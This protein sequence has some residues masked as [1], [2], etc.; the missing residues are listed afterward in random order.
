MIPSKL[1]LII[2]KASNI[3][4]QL[5]GFGYYS[6][7]DWSSVTIQWPKVTSNTDNLLPRCFFYAQN[8]TIPL[9]LQIDCW[10][11]LALCLIAF[12]EFVKNALVHLHK[13]PR[14]GGCISIC[15]SLRKEIEPFGI[16]FR[17]R[18]EHLQKRIQRHGGE[19]QSI[20][21]EESC[22]FEILQGIP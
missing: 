8:I 3:L 7:N 9:F 20:A 22:W 1:L 14:W 18:N 6:K 13:R 4:W 15:S 19:A 17:N 16:I 5:Y 21:L 10:L 12:V 11:T 2:S